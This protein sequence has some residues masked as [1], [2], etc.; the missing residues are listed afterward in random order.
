MNSFSEIFKNTGDKL[1]LNLYK[2]NGRSGLEK[3]REIVV[4]KSRKTIMKFS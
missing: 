4:E 2:V 1:I 3:K